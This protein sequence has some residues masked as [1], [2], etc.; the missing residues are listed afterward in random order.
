MMFAPA[1]IRVHDCGVTLGTINTDG[2]ISFSTDG[3]TVD[4][5]LNIE[6]METILETMKELRAQQR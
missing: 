4:S 6:E 2:E 5:G 3:I 1:S